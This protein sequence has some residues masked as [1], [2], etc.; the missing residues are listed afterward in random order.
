M[1]QFLFKSR[2]ENET[3]LKKL[4]EASNYGTFI[5]NIFG[6]DTVKIGIFR[7][8]VDLRNCVCLNRTNPWLELSSINIA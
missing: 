6:R 1:T 3:Q 7:A 2:V 8:K 5:C 4:T